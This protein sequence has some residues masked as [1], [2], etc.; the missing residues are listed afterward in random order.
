MAFCDYAYY[1]DEFH[2]NMSE[3]D[4]AY[5]AES[6]SDYIDS[7]TYGRITAETLADEKLA[8]KIKRAC[9]ACADI[10]AEIAVSARIASETVGSHSVT[11]AAA[12]NSSAAEKR[13]FDSVK[14]YLGSTGLMYRGVYE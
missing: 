6:S 4:F 2:G 5:Y 1:R 9:C 13:L 3:E 12:G 14:R 10:S 11:Y 8:R 7:V